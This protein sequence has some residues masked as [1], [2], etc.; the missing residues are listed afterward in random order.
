MARIDCR[1]EAPAGKDTIDY[2]D[3]TVAQLLARRLAADWTVDCGS[4]SPSSIVLLDAAG[5]PQ[6]RLDNVLED[7]R[8]HALMTFLMDA[9]A[10]FTQRS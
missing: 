4:G 3:W 2:R 6:S 1:W 8:Y 7:K 5:D 10:R 9:V